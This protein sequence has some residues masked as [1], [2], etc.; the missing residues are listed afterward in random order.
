MV[1]ALCFGEVGTEFLSEGLACTCDGAG[2]A[3][4]SSGTSQ[5]VGQRSGLL[6]IREQVNMKK[7]IEEREKA[8]ERDMVNAEVVPLLAAYINRPCVPLPCL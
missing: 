6:L 2:C 1:G 4:E 5:F 7:E 8:V 3:R